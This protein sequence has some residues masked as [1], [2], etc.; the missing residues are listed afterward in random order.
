MINK[1]TK[2]MAP[3]AEF[4]NVP[5]FVQDLRKVTDAGR[6][7]WLT[8]LQMGLALLKNYNPYKAPQSFDLSALL[9]KFGDSCVWR[10]RYFVGPRRGLRK[11]DQEQTNGKVS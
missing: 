9:K 7:T 6:S 8:N 10:N 5:Q 3:V 1:T 4:I 2:E 11:R